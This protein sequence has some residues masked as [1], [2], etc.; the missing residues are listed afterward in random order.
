M[1]IDINWSDIPTEWQ[2][3]DYEVIADFWEDGVEWCHLKI[4]NPL[5]SAWILRYHPE[6]IFYD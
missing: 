2:D 5:V 3:T 4:L 6:W 1:K